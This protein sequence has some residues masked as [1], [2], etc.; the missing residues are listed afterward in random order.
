[1][2]TH[3]NIRRYI[4]ALALVVLVLVLVA[5]EQ[6]T[7][8]SEPRVS[9]A[10]RATAEATA[11]AQAPSE[12]ATNTPE[13]TK[14]SEPITVPK[15]TD[16]LRPTPKPTDILR[17]TPKPTDTPE[18]P[19][20]N[21]G[22][23]TWRVGSDIVAGTYRI[24]GTDSCYWARTSDFAG[25]S[26]SII[27]NENPRGP[28]VV[29]IAPTDAGFTSKRCGTWVLAE[30]VKPTEPSAR[31]DDGTWRVGIDVVAG[32]YRSDG[33]D[34]CYWARTSDFTGSSES[35]IANDNPRGPALVTIAPTDAG[36]TCKRCDK[37]VLAETIKP[38]E[39]STQID[40]GTWRVGIDIVAGTYRS[41]GTDSCY[42]ARTSDFA[43]TS[44]SIIANDN[45]RGPA[46][47]TIA[48]TD[49]GFT[50]KRCG[51]WAPAD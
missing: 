12:Q 10:T 7:P 1:M 19:L 39:P 24:D 27:A 25:T 2:N 33:T 20:T 34:S 31:I 4:P 47:V 35:I 6:T 42:W 49:A 8:T 40:D 50:S 37:W 23:G 28:A 29:T 26:E 11:E 21:F 13:Q 14:T 15:P 9:T 16:I 51:K 48:P 32:T 44:E 22:D 18:G 5:C 43:G 30:T 36:F 38:P 17:P 3:I 41:D 45:P 46:V